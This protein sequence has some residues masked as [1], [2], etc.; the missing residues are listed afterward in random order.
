MSE[1]ITNKIQPA[2]AKRVAVF[3][4]LFAMV[5]I[6][7]WTFFFYKRLNDWT[8]VQDDWRNAAGIIAADFGS[9]DIVAIVPFWASTGERYLVGAGL[10]HRYVR[11]AANEDWAGYDKLWVLSGYGRFNDRDALISLGFKPD[12]VKQAGALQVERFSNPDGGTP[13]F[14]FLE[15]LQEAKVEQVRRGRT[16]VCGPWDA[17]L[18][19]FECAKKSTWNYVGLLNREVGFGVRPSIWAHPIQSG[20]THVLFSSVTASRRI[21][22]HTGLTLFAIAE[23]QGTPVLVDVLVDGKKVGQAVQPN[24]RGWLRHEFSLDGLENQPHEVRFVV[25]SKRENRRHFTFDAYAQ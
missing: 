3:A 24:A 8:P 13:T 16:Q 5:M 23:R 6:L 18:L 17:R 4:V 7:V 10:R 1:I 21:V 9:N 15:H 11:W 2:R 25:H 22:V 14:R 20:E 12:F 19:R